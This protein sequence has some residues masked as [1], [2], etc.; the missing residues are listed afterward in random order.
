MLALFITIVALT[1]GAAIFLANHYKAKDSLFGPDQP[2]ATPDALG[3]FAEAEAKAHNEARLARNA[4]ASVYYHANRDHVLQGQRA[5]RERKQASRPQDAG[6]RRREAI[7][8]Y[9]TPE[10]REEARQA[11]LQRLKDKAVTA[12]PRKHTPRNLGVPTSVDNGRAYQ[13]AYYQAAKATGNTATTFNNIPAAVP[14]PPIVPYLPGPGIPQ[15]GA[16][17][18]A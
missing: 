11:S 12:A 2:G 6:T 9:W 10:R 16:R 18:L 15:Y 3:Y 4:K 8:A 13:K 7:L 5:Y 17:A 1:V 14:T